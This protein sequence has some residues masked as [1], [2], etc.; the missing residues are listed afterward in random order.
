MKEERSGA[1]QFD[2]GRVMAAMC[3]AVAA[4]SFSSILI[5]QLER[6]LIAAPTIAFYRMAFATGLLIPA[7]AFFKRREIASLG[8]SE[9]KMLSFAGACLALHFA[10][11][12]SS[13][14]YIPVA[15]SVVVV[16]THPVFVVAASYFILGERVTRRSLIG[17]GLGL[18]GM[19]II[20]REALLN[21]HLAGR[22]VGLALIGALA[23]VGY[24]II[25]RKVR[26][27]IA[28]LA[29]IV[30]VYAICSA[31]LLAWTLATGASLG[32]FNWNIWVLLLGLAVVPTIIGHSVFNWAVKHVR[33]TA[34]SVA[35]L[36]EPVLASLLALMFFG[37]RPPIETLIGGVFVLAGV[38]LTTSNQPAA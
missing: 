10:A 4:L 8:L 26:G 23:V 15:T 17:A 29:Y 7:A 1:E 34:I 20:S 11:W 14:S 18:L 22:G 35:F 38:Y 12:T 33:P 28:L 32:P 31:L 16:N 3:F 2:Q 30:P 21:L 13:L 36:G 19:L 27:R 37:Q 5:T 9:L 25:G 24:F 6:A